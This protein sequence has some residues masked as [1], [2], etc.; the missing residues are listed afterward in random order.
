MKQMNAVKK[1]PIDKET[2]NKDN[3]AIP[4]TPA[5]RPSRPSI[6]LTAFVIATIQT[7]VKGT[8]NQPM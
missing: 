7:K 5:A 1:F 3:A 4:E 8:P 2:A 6:R